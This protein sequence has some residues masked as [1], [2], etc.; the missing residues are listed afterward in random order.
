MESNTITLIIF[1]NV[2]QKIVQKE[3]PKKKFVPHSIKTTELLLVIVV[4]IW[5]ISIP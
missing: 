2:N 5:N 4:Q 3:T 1:G